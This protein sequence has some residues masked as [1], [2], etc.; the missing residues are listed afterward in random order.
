SLPLL[1]RD[2]VLHV[3][4]QGAV[5]ASVKHEE[6]SHR[7]DVVPEAEVENHNHGFATGL[8]YSPILI[9]SLTSRVPYPRPLAL[10]ALLTWIHPVRVVRNHRFSGI[11]ALMV[12]SRMDLPTVLGSTVHAIVPDLHHDNSQSEYGKEASGGDNPKDNSKP[13]YSYVQLIVQ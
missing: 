8:L 1:S 7:I 11:S 12:G 4:K 5:G 13:P 10:S 6:S 9:T 3:G 2:T